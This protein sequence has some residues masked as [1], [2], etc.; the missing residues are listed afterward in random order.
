MQRR[1]AGCT[2]WRP[3]GEDYP[4]FSQRRTKRIDKDEEA[5]MCGEKG[6]GRTRGERGREGER[7]TDENERKGRMAV[8]SAA[9]K[10]DS[11]RA[12]A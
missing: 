5:G 9:K 8:E 1:V 3:R 6:R 4:A 11:G 10:S 7:E 12:F 2:M